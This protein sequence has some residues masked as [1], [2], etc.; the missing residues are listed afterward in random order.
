MAAHNGFFNLAVEGKSFVAN[1]QEF[2][3]Y[4]YTIS[5]KPSV[6]ICIQVSWL[7]PHLN[8]V[9]QGHFAVCKDRIKG[10]GGRV[11]T[12]IKKGVAFRE[13]GVNEVN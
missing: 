7:K 12:F 5:D 9:V 3:K 13:V 4:T 10:N 11:V 2:K 8:F 1:G 6:I